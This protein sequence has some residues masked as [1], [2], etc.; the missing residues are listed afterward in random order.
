MRVGAEE[1]ARLGIADGTVRFSV[2]LEDVADL[3]ADLSEA[4]D[5]IAPQPAPKKRA[6]LPVEAIVPA[7]AAPQEPEAPAA[8]AK[9]SKGKPEGRAQRPVEEAPL[10]E[11]VAALPEAPGRKR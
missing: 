1:R 6:I 4:L 5:A 9:R 8:G 10:F 7:S 2:G 3:I 11:A